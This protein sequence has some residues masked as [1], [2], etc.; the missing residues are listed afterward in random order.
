M[1]RFRDY[2]EMMMCVMC[3]VPRGSVLGP[4]LFIL[5]TAELAELA[6]RC[7]VVLHAFADGARLCLRCRTNQAEAS[8]EA[9][10]RCID[11]ISCWMSTAYV[12]TPTKPS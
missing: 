6:C 8:V 5:Y 2:D 3:S 10:E 1:H 12:S 11:A 9:L 4:L 7:G